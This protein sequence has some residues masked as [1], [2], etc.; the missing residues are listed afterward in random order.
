M[1]IIHTIEELKAIKEPLVCAM[2]TFDGLHKGHQYVIG[3]AVACAEAEKASSMVITFD[4]HPRSVL[5]DQMQ[6]PLVMT[7]EERLQRLEELHVDYIL[8][9]PM[10]KSF[11]NISA[12]EFM[13]DLMDGTM[14]RH[15]FVGENFTFGKFGKGTP[16]LLAQYGETKSVHVH[17][18]PLL[19]LHNDATKIISSTR[20][21]E[22]IRDGKME[23]ANAMLGHPYSIWSVVQHGDKRGR[24][25]GFPTANCF[26]PDELV[27]PRDGVYVTRVYVQGQWYYGIGNVGNNPTFKN[28]THRVEIHIF[29]FDDDIYDQDI[30]I[31]FLF[32]LRDEIKFNHIDDLVQQIKEDTTRAKQYIKE[33][34]KY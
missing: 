24:L 34:S 29:D 1:K 25:L 7:G 15:I 14:V 18:L 13:K 8:V 33:C 32:Y 30:Y 22:A 6:V 31:E 26:V 27:Y 4:K 9:F 20:I 23:R 19:A 21:R 5:D 16:R 17:A 28:Q 11:L 12:E 3:E 2:G 10:T